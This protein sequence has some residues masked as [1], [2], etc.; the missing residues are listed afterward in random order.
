MISQQETNF[1]NDIKEYYHDRTRTY[2]YLKIDEYN[3]DKKKCDEI[4]KGDVYEFL[5]EMKYKPDKKKET[6]K[7]NG[8]KKKQEETVEKISVEKKRAFEEWL[9]TDLELSQTHVGYFSQINNHNQV[10]TYLKFFYKMNKY[11]EI[12]GAK[13]FQLIPEL[14]TGMQHVRYDTQ[15]MHS[16][17]Q[18]VVKGQGKNQY[19][20]L[21][22]DAV[23]NLEEI[24]KLAGVS[25]K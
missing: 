17:F 6:E 13:L 16:T 15:A 9:R 2:L 1:H 3:K 8:K 12:K 21:I 24:K 25:L 20:P 22:W 19:D 4:T 11:F 7:N 23:F 14:K 18:N 10:H 5:E